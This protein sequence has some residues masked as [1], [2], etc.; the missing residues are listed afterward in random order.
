MSKHPPCP[1]SHTV[2][3]VTKLHPTHP[4]RV[5]GL[6]PYCHRRIMVTQQDGPRPGWTRGRMF[7][8]AQAPW[9]AETDFRMNRARMTALKRDLLPHLNAHDAQILIGITGSHLRILR[10]E[11]ASQL[12]GPNPHDHDL[13]RM[14]DD[15]G[16]AHD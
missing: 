7:N 11:V 10:D 8:H 12:P 2:P 4:R 9:S 3:V 13:H 14:A 16:P 15:G 6:C 5:V 1:G